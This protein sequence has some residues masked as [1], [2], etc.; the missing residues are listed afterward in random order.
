VVEFLWEKRENKVY[1]K[2]GFALKNNIIIRYSVFSA[3]REERRG[4]DLTVVSNCVL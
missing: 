2:N 4:A 3:R 1:C